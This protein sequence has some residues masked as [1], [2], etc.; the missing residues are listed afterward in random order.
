MQSI[1]DQMNTPKVSKQPSFDQEV[2]DLVTLA[3]SGCPSKRHKAFL[4][5]L[6]DLVFQRTGEVFG[7]RYY[8]DLIMAAGSPRRPST[9]TAN[10]V[11]AAARERHGLSPGPTQATVKVLRGQYDGMAQL[12]ARMEAAVDR[13]AGLV[14]RQLK[15]SESLDRRQHLFADQSLIYQR[16]IDGI[17]EAVKSHAVVAREASRAAADIGL[18]ASRAIRDLRQAIHRP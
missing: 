11:V 13:L 14:D 9:R 17:A 1:H 12:V 10:T 3:D 7:E 18:E 16:Q 2:L 15:I 4:V 5:K 8:R 6:V